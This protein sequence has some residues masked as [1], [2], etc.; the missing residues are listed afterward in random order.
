MPPHVAVTKTTSRAAA[1]EADEDF[2]SSPVPW[3]WFWL[4]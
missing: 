4:R 1:V 3:S 2:G